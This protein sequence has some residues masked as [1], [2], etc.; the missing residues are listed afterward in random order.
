MSVSRLKVPSKA[1]DEY[2]KACAAASKD[3]FK[4][5]EQHA[6]GA[7]EK[8]Q[9]YSAAWVLLGL[10]LE[11]QQRGQEARDA[12]SHAAAID[13]TYLPAYLCS[14]EF[15]ARDKQWEQV[16]SLA[17]QAVALQSEGAL[18][19][20]YYRATAYFHMK[21]LDEA[22]KSALQAVEIDVNHYEPSLYLLLAEIYVREGDTANAIVQ[23]QQLL[24]HPADRQRQDAAKQLLAKLESQPSAK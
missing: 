1:R 9:G 10:M 7:I 17:D 18:Y 11:R 14:A 5:A 22:K 21:N 6:R 15:S 12:C 8:F 13:A 4:D 23:L 16:L 2:D 24:K 20:Y 3:N 19:S